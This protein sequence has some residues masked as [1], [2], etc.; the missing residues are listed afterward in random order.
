MD[1]LLDKRIQSQLSQHYYDKNG[2]GFRIHPF[3]NM[4]ESDLYNLSTKV[5]ECYKHIQ[6]QH[7]LPFRDMEIS[8]FMN[9]YQAPVKKE[10]MQEE[11]KLMHCQFVTATVSQD[12]FNKGKSMSGNWFG[13]HLKFVEDS[14]TRPTNENYKL[15][16]ALTKEKMNELIMFTSIEIKSQCVHGRGIDSIN[17]N[18]WY[19]KCPFYKLAM[20]DWSYQQQ[21]EPRIFAHVFGKLHDM[22]LDY[23]PIVRI[24]ELYVSEIYRIENDLERMCEALRFSEVLGELFTKYGGLDE[25][26]EYMTRLWNIYRESLCRILYNQGRYSSL[27]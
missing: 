8:V 5:Y 27:C 16:Y 26:P 4:T 12:E 15:R 24:Y 22:I 1:T 19:Y 14:I 3:K 20:I 7:E 2:K 23:T 6:L 17:G 21:K 25:Q 18:Y 9:W 13:E 11:F 10:W